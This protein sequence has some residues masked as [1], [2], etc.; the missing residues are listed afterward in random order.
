M[1]STPGRTLAEMGVGSLHQ[2]LTAERP[3]KVRRLVGLRGHEVTKL[4]RKIEESGSSIGQ[5]L[6]VLQ[7]VNQ[8]RQ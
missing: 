7:V 8:S 6:Q 5:S 2:L 3:V 4:R 1:G